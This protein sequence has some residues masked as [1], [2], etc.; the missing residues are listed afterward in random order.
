MG[1]K[2]HVDYHRCTVVGNPGGVLGVFWQILLR[3]VLGVVRKSGR[4]GRG[5]CFIAFLCGSLLKIFIGVHEVPPSPHPVCIYVDYRCPRVAEV[6]VGIV[7]RSCLGVN[8][9]ASLW[10]PMLSE[11]IDVS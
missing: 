9:D 4:W 6:Q 7:Y 10:G 3:V 8:T 5:S 1:R 2:V 11:E